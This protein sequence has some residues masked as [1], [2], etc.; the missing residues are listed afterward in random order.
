[1]KSRFKALLALTA[2]SLVMPTSAQAQFAR[3]GNAPH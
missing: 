1:M 3:G 2:L